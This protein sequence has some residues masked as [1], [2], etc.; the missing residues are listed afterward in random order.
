M[1]MDVA[2]LEGML[3]KSIAKE[4][5]GLYEEILNIYSSDEEVLNL[6]KNIKN[7]CDYILKVYREIPNPNKKLDES[8]YTTLYNMLKD[9]SV[10]FYDLTVAD[11]EQLYYVISSAYHKLSGAHN[12]LERLY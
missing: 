6:A 9:F 2:V 4:I 3:Y 12:L 11:G 7:I 5:E 1:K 10:T 8:L